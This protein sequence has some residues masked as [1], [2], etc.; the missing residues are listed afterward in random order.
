VTGEAFDV[1]AGDV[2][3]CQLALLAPGGELAQIQGVR[4]SG[5][6]GVAARQAEQCLLLEIAE[7][8]VSAALHGQ[9]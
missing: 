6:T 9:G 3:Q 8:A 4:I 1:V 7:D 5:E 2:E